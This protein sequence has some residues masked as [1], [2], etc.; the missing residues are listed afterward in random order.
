METASGLSDEDQKLLLIEFGKAVVTEAPAE[1]VLR[2]PSSIVPEVL[3]PVDVV[4]FHGVD[5][6]AYQQYMGGIQANQ[7]Q[8]VGVMQHNLVS[9]AQ[10]RLAEAYAD[11]DMVVA[12]MKANALNS[13]RVQLGE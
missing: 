9:Y 2:S 7:Q 6:K 1:M 5:S 8:R 13:A 10:G 4:E 11:I 3:D 12:T